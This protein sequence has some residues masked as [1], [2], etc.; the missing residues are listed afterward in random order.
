[1]FP[2]TLCVVSFSGEMEPQKSL[3]MDESLCDIFKDTEFGDTHFGGGDLFSIL[4]SLEDL[5]DFPSTNNEAAVIGPTFKENEQNSKK[6][7]ISSRAPQD[8]ETEPE[9]SPKSKRQK[10]SPTLVEEP[11]KVSHIT[12][13]RNRRK[14]MNENLSILRS[15]MPF[16]YVKRVRMP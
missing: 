4:E 13:E 8:S 10:L 12:V 14:E 11:Q 1:M 7:S 3:L 15:L 5:K 2:N 9:I 6:V 16:F